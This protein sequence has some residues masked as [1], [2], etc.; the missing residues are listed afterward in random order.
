M[1]FILDALRKVDR[2][3]R[4]AEEVVPPVAAMDRAV[5]MTN[6]RREYICAP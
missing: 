5:D 3:T 1:S 6:A 4:E 2:Q